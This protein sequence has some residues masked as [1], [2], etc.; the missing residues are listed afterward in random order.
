MM[1]LSLSPTS[2]LHRSDPSPDWWL[3]LCT[4]VGLG[5]WLLSL[6]LDAWPAASADAPVELAIG[7]GLPLLSADLGLQSRGITFLDDVD[8]VNLA[9][10]DGLARVGLDAS[11]DGVRI[12][13]RPE[14]ASQVAALAQHLGQTWAVIEIEE[15]V[16]LWHPQ[17]FALVLAVLLVMNIGVVMAWRQLQ[18]LHGGEW[19]RWLLVQGAAVPTLIVSLLARQSLRIA[20]LGGFALVGLL[21]LESL[22]QV[23]PLLV[24]LG[25]GA[26]WLAVL[27]CVTR[28][29]RPWLW[30]GVNGWIG[31]SGFCCGAASGIGMSTTAP[32]LLVLLSAA[33]L[34]LAP[35]LLVWFRGGTP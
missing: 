33:S 34:V 4:L 21:G 30:L 16:E 26:V 27:L 23:L 19:L 15:L 25:L 17:R 22:R 5:F 20:A 32:V 11:T 35:R 29:T 24:M 18:R 28:R 12:V 1:P 13:H 6:R 3:L 14:G 7:R 8:D 10:A 31:V 9:V 2:V